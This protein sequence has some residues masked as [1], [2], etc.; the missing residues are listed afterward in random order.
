VSIPEPNFSGHGEIFNGAKI[1]PNNPN[2]H[3][4]LQSCEPQLL[5]VLR[6]AGAGH[7]QGVGR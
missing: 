6:T 5:A 4:A 7:I 3:T 2:Y 1:N